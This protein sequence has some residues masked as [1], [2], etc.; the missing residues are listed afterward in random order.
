MRLSTTF[1][2][3]LPLAAFAQTPTISPGGIVNAADAQS[4]LTPGSLFSIFGTNL[5]LQTSSAMSIPLSTSLGG[6]TV[7]FV[8][9]STTVNAP[10]LYV[11]PNGASG[12]PSQINAQVP[13]EIVT[14]GVTQTV[15]VIVSSNGVS[16][17]PTPVTI[18][19]FSPGIFASGTQAVAVNYSDG[20]LAWPANS[21]P[22]VATH[23]AKPGDVIILYCTGLG[24]VSPSVADGAA[25]LDALRTAN[26]T[27]VVLVGG[28][29][30][31]VPFA[32]LSPQFVGVNQINFIVPNAAPGNAVPI[33][34]MVG[35]ITS[36]STITM[37]ITSQ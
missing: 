19:P 23:P 16:S 11:Q 37:A 8:N 5:S 29:S 26:T 34:I 20:T 10:M 22:G 3:L 25:S 28:L 13:W 27:P 18:G 36:P 14:P 15:N 24:A 6:V 33:Q 31:M 1:F 9:G 12:V 30:A 35:G 21:I 4:P 17:A 7:Q 32:G 2:A